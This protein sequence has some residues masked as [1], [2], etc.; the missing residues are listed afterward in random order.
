M[1]S[2]SVR[3]DWA[4][5]LPS[6]PECRNNPHEPSAMSKFWKLTPAIALTT[7]VALLLASVAMAVYN[8]RSYRAQKVKEVGV[9]A[10]ILASSVTAALVFNDPRTAQEYVKALRANPEIRA[11]AVY[12]AS[13]SLFASYTRA[14]SA[15]LPETAQPRE[16]Y[17]EDNRLIVVNPVRQGDSTVGTVYLRTITESFEQRLA[18]YGGIGLLI[19]MASLVVAVLGAAQAAL[20]RANRELH[21]QAFDLAEANT[22]LHAQIEERE[23]A[24]AALRQAQIGRAHV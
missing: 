13:G 2:R 19:V 14:G 3:K 24:E 20:T 21:D 16:P 1:A 15:P 17:F 6:G 8:E 22:R 7:V 23:K 11:A 5:R 9:Q 18:R 12:D 10:Q 4:L